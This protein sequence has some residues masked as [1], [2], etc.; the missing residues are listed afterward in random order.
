MS[1]PC[2]FS[3]IRIRLKKI[4]LIIKT[5]RLNYFDTKKLDH[6]THVTH[7]LLLSQPSIFQQKVRN[8]KTSSNKVETFRYIYRN[9][10]QCYCHNTHM[11][12]ISNTNQHGSQWPRGLTRLCYCRINC[13]KNAKY[14]IREIYR[15]SPVKSP[16]IKTLK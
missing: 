2:Q 16:D 11:S 15:Q 10:I 4:T 7:Y 14:C 9:N 8:F 1:P 3:P 12:F 13:H 5:N 6:F